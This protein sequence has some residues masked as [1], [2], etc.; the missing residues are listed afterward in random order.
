MQPEHEADHS[1]PFVSEKENMWNLV[2]VLYT[3][4]LLIHRHD[5]GIK[6]IETKTRKQEKK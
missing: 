3:P 2:S 5:F 1:F 6:N 4:Q